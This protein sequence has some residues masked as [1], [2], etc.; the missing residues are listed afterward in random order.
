MDVSDAEVRI[1]DRA[2]YVKS[3]QDICDSDFRRYKKGKNVLSDTKQN[4]C[5]LLL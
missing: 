3:G 5:F 1:S 2:P 4:R